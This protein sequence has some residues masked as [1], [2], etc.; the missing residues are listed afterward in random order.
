MHSTATVAPGANYVASADSA[1]I[2]LIAAIAGRIVS[3]VMQQDRDNGVC[4]CV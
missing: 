1:V 3:A 2:H 4:A